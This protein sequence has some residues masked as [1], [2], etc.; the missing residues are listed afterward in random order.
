MLFSPAE[1]S[2]SVICVMRTISDLLRE[3]S[4]DIRMMVIYLQKEKVAEVITNMERLS[5]ICPKLPIG[6]NHHS[7]WVT[8]VDVPVWK[9]GQLSS[10]L[11]IV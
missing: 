1:P 2:V 11:R 5:V 7:V 9:T 4:C 8:S 6:I 10:K 3:V